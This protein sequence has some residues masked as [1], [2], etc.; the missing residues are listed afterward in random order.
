MQTLTAALQH[1]AK[2]R[3]E[4]PAVLY[5]TLRIG[6]GDLH[7]RVQRLA[8]WLAEAGVGRGSVVAL[9]MKN[10]PAFIDLTFSI[11]W[12]G[13]ILLPINYR[14]SPEEIAY[15][16]SDSEAALL[17]VDAEFEAL[18][19]TLPIR[20]IVLSTALQ[21]DPEGLTLGG[22]QPPPPFHP[23]PGDLFRLMYT[24]GTTD[25]PK[26]VM[27][28]YG[29]L[30]WKVAGQVADLAIASDDR[31]C[32][33]GPLYHVGAS[34]LPGLTVL[35]MGGTISLLREF[36]AEAVL[37]TIERDRVTGIWMA[38]VMTCRVLDAA[39]RG[40]WDLTSLRWCIAGGD[41]T[42]EA[43]IRQFDG[44]FPNARYIDSYGLT[45]TCSG[46]TT[47]VAG[48]EIA[49]IGSVGR[50]LPNVEIEIR[51][52]EGTPLASGTRGEICIRGGKVTAGYWNDS[53]RTAAAFWP[54]GWFRS[55]D[56]GYLDADGYL[57]LVDRQKDLIISGGENISP[58]EI[59]RVVREL[60]QVDDV[61]VVARADPEWGERPVAFAVIKAGGT[62][63]LAELTAHCR[64]HL[65]GFKVPKELH[66]V[67]ELPRNPS[68]KVLRRALR[69]RLV[70]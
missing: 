55:G 24:S 40:T 1:H 18:T 44:V 11:S 51:D 59:E 16:A 15:I 7:A 41:R 26:G 30:A 50:P 60:Q 23:S 32:I 38:P 36:S 2:T 13:G 25:R 35:M 65:A 53:A 21:S 56:L 27:H 52:E 4:A 10:S 70:K 22:S 5:G 33:T 45:E 63:D 3:P 62:L 64:R 29:N 54:D 19:E 28:S 17:V 43:R 67:D 58:S 12:L 66:L 61:A 69:D 37:R 31:L 34:D 8:A 49:K 57:F 42:P 46:D 47:M 20:R 68:G 48:M 14:L 9:V 39:P 6:W